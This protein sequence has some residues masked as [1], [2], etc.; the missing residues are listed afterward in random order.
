[1]ISLMILIHHLLVNGRFFDL[2]DIQSPRILWYDIFFTTGLILLFIDLSTSKKQWNYFKKTKDG[3]GYILS[4]LNLLIFIIISSSLS[5]LT[6]LIE[7]IG[8]P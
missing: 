1:M 8:I 7:S 5:E 4:R 6:D 3:G 2:R